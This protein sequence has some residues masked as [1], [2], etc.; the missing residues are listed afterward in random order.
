MVDLKV[1]RISILIVLLFL[2]LFYI[3][4][5]R[6]DFDNVACARIFKGHFSWNI[7]LPLFGVLLLFNFIELMKF[8]IDKKSKL[9][10]ALL[11]VI[12]LFVVYFI[13]RIILISYF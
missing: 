13:L 4:Y 8:K 1:S 2:L 10:G 7:Y 11:L 12:P 6:P 3:S 9:E 5:D